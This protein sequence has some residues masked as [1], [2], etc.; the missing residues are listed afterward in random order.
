MKII[1]SFWSKPL[2]TP[3]NE[4]LDSRAMGGFP[5]RKYFIYT[6]ALSILRL[7]EHFD[8]VHL[9]TD[10]FGKELLLYA[11]ELPYTSFSTELNELDDMPSQFWCA[12]K[13]HVSAN[14]DCP[15]LH[16]DGDLILGDLFDKSLL[17]QPLIAEFHYEDK[18]KNYEPTLNLLRQNQANLLISNDL[19]MTIAQP[20]Y[21]YNDYN[22]GVVGGN[23]Y[24]FLNDYA[25]KSLAMI[26][27][28][29]DSIPSD[30][31]S[32]SFTNCLIEQL[33]FYQMALANHKK[34]ALCIKEKF[35]TTYD[36]QAEVLG[37]ITTDF[38]F[39]HFHGNYKACYYEVA[40]QWL[41]H[42]YPKEYRN[43]NRILFGH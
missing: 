25:Q 13:L 33:N 2:L 7:R 39:I 35:D 42:Y 20:D 22:L 28:N 19:K 14:T 30:Q 29:K 38:E 1:Q 36:Y 34:V 43:I 21:I 31:I 6:W 40:E 8:E 24:T 37:K 15:F 3:Y 27:A 12:G 9:V 41:K 32:I 5:L 16:I 11:L 10:D 26:E 4:T 18:V 23:D 17:N